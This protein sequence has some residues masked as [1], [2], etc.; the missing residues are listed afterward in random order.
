MVQCAENGGK[1]VRLLQTQNGDRFVLCYC[2][3]SQS[4]SRCKPLQMFDVA[5]PCIFG[6]GALG[7]GQAA[8][9]GDKC[10][11]TFRSLLRNLAWDLGSCDHFRQ[12]GL[13]P[14]C[15]FG[16]GGRLRQTRQ[17]KQK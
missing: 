9:E 14:L 6:A 4:F 15:W 13:H 3:K 10:A 1:Y 16:Q 12:Q 7:T 11:L 17:H 2:K 5:L 8:R